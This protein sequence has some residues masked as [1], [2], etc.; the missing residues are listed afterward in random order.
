MPQKHACQD[1]RLTMPRQTI[2]R[3]FLS[4]PLAALLLALI[5]AGTPA[6][7]NPWRSVGSGMEYTDLQDNGLTPWSHIHA[8]RVDLKN[9]RFSTMLAQSLGKPHASVHELAANSNALIASNGGFFDKNYRPLGLR[10]SNHQLLSPLKNVSW[11]GVFFTD[12][13]RARIESPRHFHRT[14]GMDFA[15]QSGP[16]LL[17]NGQIPPLRPGRAERTA[18]CIPRDGRVIL[19]VT[20]NTPLTTTELA[21]RLRKSPLHCMDA[22]NLDGGSSSQLSA[23]VG[24]FRLS[25]HGFANV[26]DALLIS[27]R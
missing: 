3:P 7:A 19:V 17:V 6:E 12:G 10:L 16:R 14:S 23:R 26:S 20:D 22:L 2:Q 18:L 13:K 21:Q 11:W 4:A 9:Y 15:I 27:H 8:F 24:D 5:L 25:V 1:T